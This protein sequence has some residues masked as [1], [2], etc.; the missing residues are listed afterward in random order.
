MSRKGTS[1]GPRRTISSRTVRETKTPPITSTMARQAAKTWGVPV[2]TLSAAALFWTL[3]LLGIWT[4]TTAVVSVAGALLVLTLFSSFQHYFFAADSGHRYA[5]LG[6]AVVWGVFVFACFYR[7]NFPGD[8]V[9]AGVLHA[10]PET[11]AV[12]AAGRFAVVVD[13]RFTTTEGQG[14]RLGHYRLDAISGDTTEQ[15]ITGDFEDTFARQRLG[16]RGSTT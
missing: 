12:P 3:A 16:R 4:D 2:I 6:F 8:P 13:G 15:S 10:G 9:A 7:Q 11:L 5:A 14:N 1:S